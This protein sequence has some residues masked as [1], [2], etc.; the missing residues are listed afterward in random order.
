[1]ILDS[2]QDGTIAHQNGTNLVLDN[3]HLTYHAKQ[4]LN[5][6]VVWNTM[7]TPRGR[8][9]QLILPDG[10]KVW[11]NASSSITYPTAFTGNERNVRIK[12]EVYFEVAKDKRRQF[13]VEVN[14]TTVAVLGTHFNINSYT[15][16]LSIKTTLIEEALK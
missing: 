4:S 11:L 1:M 13:L 16:E 7:S 9:F 8:Q 3:G 2:V 5:N 6:K 12:G 14:G 15:D 10:T